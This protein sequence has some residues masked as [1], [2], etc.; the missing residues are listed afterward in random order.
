[1]DWSPD[2]KLF[3]TEGTEDTG[4]VDIRDAVTGE[5]VHEFRADAID[6]NDAVFSRDSKRVVTASDEGAIRVW[7]IATGRKA[8]RRHGRGRRAGVGTVRQP[9]RPSRRGGVARAQQGAGVPRHRRQALGDPRR[10]A[11]DTAFSPDGRRLAV[12][13]GG[14]GTVHVVDLETRR[15]VFVLDPNEG[16]LDLAWSPDGRWLAT[17]GSFGASVYDARTGRL[18]PV[19]PGPT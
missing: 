7:D 12:A 15:E 8:G 5:T 10:Y 11:Q 13:A 2:G 3:V 4:L 16:V 19:T 6:L 9:R 18:S 17:S 1:M 14:S